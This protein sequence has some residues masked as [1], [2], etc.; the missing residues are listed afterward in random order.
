MEAAGAQLAV[1]VPTGR[2][3]WVAAGA[4]IRGHVALYRA[5]G[6]RIGHRI[7][8]V[9]NMLLLDHLG[10]RSGRRRTTPLSYIR[11]GDDYVIVASKGGHPR[12]PAWFHNLRA[13]PDTEIQVGSQRLSVHARAAEPEERER[14][15]RKVVNTYAGFE[16]YQRRTQRQIPLVVLT[17]RR[18]YPIEPT[19]SS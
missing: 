9:R 2:A 10:A 12:H 14:L 5:T 4:A 18:P 8:R 3:F 19:I 16:G 13:N 15:W 7:P 17:P 1:N 11:D 6:G